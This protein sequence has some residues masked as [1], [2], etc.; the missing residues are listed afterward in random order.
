[1]YYSLGDSPCLAPARAFLSTSVS[2]QRPNWS[3]LHQESCHNFHHIVIIFLC[4]I[5]WRVPLGVQHWKMGRCLER[6][7]ELPKS[8]DDKTRQRRV[9][10]VISVTF[11]TTCQHNGNVMESDEDNSIELWKHSCQ[12]NDEWW[13][14]LQ[15]RRS[16]HSCPH[17]LANRP[18]NNGHRSQ[19]LFVIVK[20]P[21]QHLLAKWELKR[22]IPFR[23]SLSTWL[24]SSLIFYQDQ[25]D[26]KNGYI[27]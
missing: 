15:C 7:Q 27:V 19:L 20:H 2:V 14:M 16:D 3:G 12:H 6:F 8:H 9:I 23:F 5:I 17:I 18:N 22:N 11:T 4:L 21:C 24:S 13:K 1:M 26:I 25:W 10:K